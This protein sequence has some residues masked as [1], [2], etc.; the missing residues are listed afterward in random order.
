MAKNSNYFI[1]FDLI[2]LSVLQDRDRY[3]YEITKYI[4]EKTN[5]I[6]IPKQGTIYH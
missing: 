4:K 2:I 3:A 6:I 5:G 1:K